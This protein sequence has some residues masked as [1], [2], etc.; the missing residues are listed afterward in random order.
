MSYHIPKEE[1]LVPFACYRKWDLEDL[2][3]AMDA[4]KRLLQK[5]I[6]YGERVA[7]ARWVRYDTN[8]GEA[9]KKGFATGDPEI[10]FSLAESLKNEFL[11]FCK[12]YD[13]EYQFANHATNY[14][15]RCRQLVYSFYD[16]ETTQGE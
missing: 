13:C 15:R 12:K 9:W 5:Q 10:N 7:Y 8:F 6:Y 14:Y 1:E 11:L 3:N 4:P 2:L 16:S